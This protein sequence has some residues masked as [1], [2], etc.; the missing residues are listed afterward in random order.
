MRTSGF[1]LEQREF[2]LLAV[3]AGWSVRDV[4]RAYGIARV[5]FYR[6]KAEVAVPAANPGLLAA[7]QAGP[8]SE[9]RLL[10]ATRAL[11]VEAGGTRKAPR[12]RRPRVEDA[13]VVEKLQQLAD[14]YSRWGYRRLHGLLVKEGVD[15]GPMRTYRLYQAEGL[16]TRRERANFH[17]TGRV[18]KPIEPTRPNEVWHLFFAGGSLTTGR[19]FVVWHIVDAFT[20]KP[21]RTHYFRQFQRFRTQVFLRGTSAELG[22]P[23]QLHVRS[24]APLHREVTGWARVE[25]VS[26]HYR[27]DH[28][29]EFAHRVQ[30]LQCRNEQE[31]LQALSV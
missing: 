19:P 5:T 31:V 10:A 16:A 20:G 26:L 9:A 25:R 1:T 22:A 2:A 23:A 21:L 18:G 14:R 12:T 29:G 13:V 15:V 27:P 30:Q 17:S 11:G 8:L 28:S 3:E 7:L 24:E 6:W 4:C